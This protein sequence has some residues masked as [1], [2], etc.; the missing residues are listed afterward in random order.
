MDGSRP[1]SLTREMTRSSPTP[2]ELDGLLG[3]HESDHL[4]FKAGLRDPRSAARTLAALANSGGGH[5]VVGWDERGKSVMPIKEKEV[6]GLLNRAA[7]LTRPPLV[8]RLD[9][10][11][12][13][14]HTVIVATV[15]PSANGNLAVAPDGGVMR[16]DTSGRAI[17][18][19]V[20][21]AL[22]ALAHADGHP[23][24]RTDLEQLTAAFADVQ[25]RLADLQ[26]ASDEHALVSAAIETQTSVMGIDLRAGFRAAEVER[27]L[28][29]RFIEWLC[30]GVVGAVIALVLH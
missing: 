16:R 13:D 21:D 5:L 12:R 29:R 28:S 26:N 1:I 11:G 24:D 15:E 10:V 27:R 18:V 6:A 2:P 8:V 17:P 23:V 20:P 25:Q 30:A 22:R 19:S 9:A 14:G 3:Q 7:G 4:E